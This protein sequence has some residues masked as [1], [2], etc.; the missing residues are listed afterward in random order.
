MRDLEG[1]TAVITGAASGMGRAFA[2]RLA[3]AGM[4][5]VL[6]DIEPAPLQAAVAELKKQGAT[7]IGVV[8]DVSSEHDMAALRTRSLEQYGTVDVV[9]LNAGVAGG[10]GPM[11]TLTVGDWQWTLGVNLWGI[12]HGIHTFV[13][14]LKR[15]DS[16]HVVITAS[17][18]GL[19]S[20]P[21]MGPYNVSKHSA[22][23]IAETLFSELRDQGSSV[24]VSCLCPGVVHTNIITSERNRPEALRRPLIEPERTNEDID[25]GRASY[26]IFM[27]AKPPHEVAELVHDAIV[28]R[29]FWILTDEVFTPEIN[30]R[31]DAIRDRADPTARGTLL[32]V[33]YT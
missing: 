31:L 5:V 23:A 33:Y 13:P 25:R 22:V 16:G 9:C 2:D 11:E 6:A 12:I 1:K 26:E 20:F 29:R 30:R 10:T 18:A 15:N 24:G 7:A 8:T 4:R 3:R 27:N 28:E 17:I 19:T 21:N 32:D 14:D